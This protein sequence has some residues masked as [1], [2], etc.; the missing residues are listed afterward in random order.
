MSAADYAALRLTLQPALDHFLSLLGPQERAIVADVVAFAREILKEQPRK[1]RELRRALAGEF[2]EC[3]DRSLGMIVRMSPP[4]VMIPTGDRWGF[5]GD[6]RVGLA[7][8]WLEERL[9]PAAPGML[10]R[11]YLAAFGPASAADIQQWSGLTGLKSELDALRPQLAV[12]QDEHGRQLLDLPEAPRPAPDTP[13]PP[14]F[15]PPFDNLLL[16]H[17]DR[18]R[19]LSEEHRRI[20]FAARN[21]RI[22]GTF[23]VDG[24]VAGIWRADRV[25]KVATLTMAPFA[26]LEPN[27]VTV[28]TAEANAL[29]RF[30]EDAVHYEVRWQETSAPY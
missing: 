20:V 4:L 12:F 6:S 17:G 21:G 1:F 26:T 19:I 16:S 3:D 5:P 22:P 7:E 18:T 29:L 13:A 2:P 14:R 10:I 8:E 27:T 9:T 25:K 15:L 28:L 24:F 30:L 23:L 11:R